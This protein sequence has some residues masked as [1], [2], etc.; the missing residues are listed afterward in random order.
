[1]FKAVHAETGEEIIIL[2][3]QW[4]KKL[5]QLREM[6]RADLLLCQGCGQA[7]R[8]KAGK[9]KRAHFAHKHRKACSL[10][11]ETVEILEARA[12]LYEWLFAQFGAAVSVEK[13]VQEWALPRPID[14][15]VATEQ[16]TFAYWLIENGIR[17]ERREA[18]KAA[19]EQA[20]VHIHYVFLAQML[21][22]EKKEFHSL[23]L[24]PT[25]R[26]FR[27]ETPFDALFARPGATGHS[28]H[29]LDAGQGLLT[30]FRSLALFHRPNWYKGIK[31]S[32]PLASVRARVTDGGFVHPGEGE[33]LNTY[34]QK[35]ARLEREQ[36]QAQARL[37]EWNQRLAQFRAE[38]PEAP[39]AEAPQAGEP[40]TLDPNSAPAP[41]PE[42]EPA[43]EGAA[44]PCVS[45]G[46]I[47]TDYWATFYDEAG[48][49]LCRC[50]DCLDRELGA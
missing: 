22:E 33:R 6:D 11:S 8:V 9:L 23:L 2:H 4:K 25:E 28:L 37:E 15:W 19:F 44:L 13:Q 3:P 17:L 1:M 45:C 27:R 50:R 21:N 34:R 30:T 18:I 12:V 38:Q 35:Q 40:E 32:D 24:T 16:G 7:M 43:S 41:R 36:E 26:A 20:E 10:G 39:R 42:P 48:R 29:Y 46:Q 49:K 5:Q 47:T 31:H 14:C